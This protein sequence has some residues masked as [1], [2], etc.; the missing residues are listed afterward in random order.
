[1][2]QPIALTIAASDP[3]GCAGIAADLR[4]FYALGVHGAVCLT[5]ATIQNTRKFTSAF[6]ISPQ[7][8]GA[9]L[10]AIFSDMQ[11]ASVKIGFIAGEANVKAVADSLRKWKAKNIVL[12]PVMS[13]Q[14]DGLEISHA[15]TIAAIK[16]HLVPLCTFITPNMH[17]ATLL[18][19]AKTPQAAASMLRKMGAKNIVVKGIR[20]GAAITDY[21]IVGGRHI[22]LSKPLAHTGTH[23]GGCIFSSAIA[24]GLASG[25]GE[26]DAL[27]S[28]EN[29]ISSSIANAWKPGKGI[30]AVEPLGSAEHRKV[31]SE[32]AGALAD[33]EA[34]AN[35]WKI[36]PEIATNI[37]YALPNAKT[38]GDVAGV[39][40]R[41]R[42]TMNSA[43]SLGILDFGGS[44]HVARM[45]LT[46][47]KY[48]PEARSAMNIAASE[49]IFRAIKKHGI[50]LA[51]VDRMQEPP[52]IAEKEGASM[53]WLV[54]QAMRG[55]KQAPK[56]IYFTGSI[57]K[58]PSIV[59]FGKSPGE[60][61][62]IA[63]R[64]ADEISR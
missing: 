39:T 63:L 52:S 55:R 23:G 45:L 36:L 27:N 11:I 1:M 26:I 48:V 50:S 13:S 14:P 59:L 24:A 56:A 21:T 47:Q 37:V 61:V 32:L 57:G 5:A 42:R 35:S 49:E 28:A 8:I 4:T 58:E 44:S 38:T 34:D 33:F 62:A 25:K 2:K 53:Q 51:P 43:R 40:G 22:E 18:T 9:Q 46:Y 19:G 12:D 41:I 3:D 6:A 30:A 20:K 29:F 10:D 54:A 16:I 15:R 7:A 64:L 31:L 60:I 17:E